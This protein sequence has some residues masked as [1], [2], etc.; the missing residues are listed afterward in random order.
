MK[1]INLIITAII[2]IISSFILYKIFSI[3][4]R[5]H[6]NNE[7]IIGTASGYAPFVSIDEDG[8]YEGFDID[9]AKSLAEIMNKKLVIKDLGS[10][11]SL[12]MALEQGSID[13]IIWGMSIT[14]D[15]LKKVSMIHYQGESIASYPLIFWKNIPDTINGFSDMDGMIIC[16]EPTSVQDMVLSRYPLIH[17]KQTERID[18][19]LLNIQYEKAEAAFVEEA[20]AKK[21]KNKYPEIKILDIALSQEDQAFGNGIVIKKENKPLIEEVQKAVT[22]LKK[23]N[24]I[25]EYENKWNIR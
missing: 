6:S 7:L 8:E 17:K 10:M 16:V 4:N 2:L 1:C 18:D 14:K 25:T 12:F 21:F 23:S 11:T 15:R 13:A 20:I 22:L 9:V 5:V 3:K 19:A 24:I